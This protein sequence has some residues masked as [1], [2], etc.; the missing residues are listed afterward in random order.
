[1]SS[2]IKPATA[3]TG[4]ASSLVAVLRDRAPR[5]ALAVAA[6]QAAW[7]AGV[8]ARRLIREHRTYTVK[9][10]GADGIYDDVHEWVLGLLPP[11]DRR[12]LI[13]HSTAPRAARDA[14]VSVSDGYRPP[15]AMLRL[16]YDG[17]RVQSIR[18][19]GHRV[20]VSVC[21]AGQDAEGREGGMWKPPEIM[22]TAASVDGRQAVLDEINRVLARASASERTPAIR[23]LGAWGGWDR[24]DDLPARPV[25]SVILAGG[26]M[27]RLQ[28]D[29]GGFLAAEGDY[30]RRG[31]PWH[32][33]YLFSGPP[34]GGKTSVAHALAGHFG[35]DLWYLPLNDVKKDGELLRLATRVTPR[36][37]LL[38]EDVDVFRAATE[39]DDDGDVT[40][41]GLLN[42]LDGIATPHGLI[43]I[44]T[45]NHPDVLDS[46]ILRPGRADMCEHFGAADP[47][48]VAR[49]VSHFYGAPVTVADTRGL[50]EVM[51]A[52]VMEA[53]KRCPGPPEALASLRGTTCVAGLYEFMP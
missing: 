47:G 51:P 23:M 10:S 9:I 35:M 19:R 41:S 12:A 24:L 27:E 14:P 8:W 33:G 48:Q 4:G 17:S 22:F 32:R 42:A 5:L 20:Q 28:A 40:L 3:D 39:R 44:M 26:Q 45:T 11:G 1:M 6:G 30:V 37:I 16:R 36:S 52:A 31:I 29:I 25:E 46:A 2:E 18:V 38:L 7:P 43:T 13:A 15:E 34:G 49:L 53:C 21:E 50:P